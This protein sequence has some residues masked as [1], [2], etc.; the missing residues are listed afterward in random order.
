MINPRIEEGI[1]R[2]SISKRWRH[3]FR[4]PKGSCEQSF[5]T[6]ISMTQ[7][8]KLEALSRYCPWPSTG[9]PPPVKLRKRS[10]RSR[11]NQ[12][13]RLNSNRWYKAQAHWIWMI[14]AIGI[15]M[16]SPLASLSYDDC[17]LGW[18]QASPTPDNGRSQ[19]FLPCWKHSHLGLLPNRLWTA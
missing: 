18:V 19:S 16:A 11:W 15:T 8:L 1:R 14:T 4:K 5:R 17:V 12:V 9:A 3:G 13:M 10:H 6:S 2:R 7:N